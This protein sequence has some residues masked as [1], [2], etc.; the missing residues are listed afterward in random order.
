V[1]V[2]K[3]TCNYEWKRVWGLALLTFLL[4]GFASI[5][6]WRKIRDGAEGSLRIETQVTARQLAARLQGWI[7]DR[8][9][10]CFHIRDEIE[11]SETFDSDSYRARA[12][13]MLRNC[14][15]IQALSWLDAAG[16]IR[17]VV[18]AKGNEEAL[19]K[20]LRE[21]PLPAVWAAVER[22]R[23]TGKAARTPFV[24]LYQGGRGF[25]VYLPVRGKGGRPPGFLD[26]VFRLEP[27]IDLSTKDP[28]LAKR[29][30]FSIEDEAGAEVS[31]SGARLDPACADF[32]QTVPV[33][34]VDRDWILHL[35]PAAGL[36]RAALGHAAFA[37]WGGLLLSLALGVLVF[38]LGVRK[39]AFAEALART[40]RILA[41]TLDGYLL[42]D[43]QGRILDVNAA[44]E[45]L[46]GYD[47]S[48][49]LGK[50]IHDLE[51]AMSPEEVDRKIPEILRA[52]HSRF[53]T[54]HR[55]KDGTSVRLEV[56][57]AAM[58]DKRGPL[59]AAFVRDI[60]QRRRI[61]RERARLAKAVEQAAE[62]I[63]IT[64]PEARLEYVNP[65]FERMSGYDREEVLGRNPSLLKSG[66][67]ESSFYERMW[68]ALMRGEIWSG[69]F[70]NRRKDEKL[71]EVE[72][73]ISPVRDESGILR[74]YVGVQ[75]DMTRE[76]EME[77]QLLQ[78][79]KM[80][81]VGQLAGGVAHDFN[82]L[83]TVIEGHCDI[84]L[85]DLA[86]DQPGRAEVGEIQQAAQRASELTRQLL[87]FSRRQ[88]LRPRV[89]DLPD[90]VENLGA[91]LR[92]LIG[93]DIELVFSTQESELRVD[94]DPNQIEQVLVNLAVNARDAMPGGGKLRLETSLLRVG[95]G[96]IH[97]DVKVPA[98][99]YVKLEVTDTGCGMD[100][101]TRQ[102]AFEPFFTTKGSGRGTGLGLSTAYGI[103]KQSGGFIFVTSAPGAGARFEILLPRS[104]EAVHS[105]P[106]P[107]P[108][109]AE[110]R[111]DERVLVVEDE[112]SVCSLA[113]TVLKTAG[114]SVVT[115]DNPEEALRLAPGAGPFDLLVSDMIMPGMSGTEM[116]ERLREGAPGL[117][118]LFMS[119]YPGGSI[120]GGSA[121]TR[122]TP[123]LAKPFTPDQLLA[124]VREVLDRS[125]S[126]AGA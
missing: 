32:R 87:A 76:R 51:A 66:E 19:G 60:T 1:S 9:R 56:S 29:F 15:G 62:A 109:P 79:Q 93:E 73:S 26:I 35:V 50:K 84:L 91:I 2:Q 49:L 10:M 99:D 52:G 121:V 68:A 69:T 110:S 14:R 92:R 85:H 89:F 39:R 12:R 82:N 23:R 63:L 122:D 96:A 8:V 20:N 70:I 55:R 34:I 112:P 11:Q 118:V 4:A 72:A 111:G 81:A 98:G 108:A 48:E 33:R 6:V 47:R 77:R 74:H 13:A 105:V 18:P 7:D 65:A 103:V 22:A 21:H 106:D 38:F 120:G 116:A 58:P 113:K 45:R 101:A 64:D 125:D 123:F 83:L 126:G 104:P 24:R 61:E 117:K 59:V 44:Y 57:L 36:K 5:A 115:A 124:K 86:P 17:I 88:T 80:E 42:A 3:G 25:V 102:R 30:R 54:W 71:Y 31:S 40:E 37:L 67:H 53:V 90:R 41:T 27:F 75:R 100:E 28:P 95:P 43:D 97:A 46:V 119:G 16:V 78:A 94:A 107:P 114:Y